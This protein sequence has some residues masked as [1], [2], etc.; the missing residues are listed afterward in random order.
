MNDRQS[1]SF[2]LKK[3]FH[4]EGRRNCDKLVNVNHNKN[5]TNEAKAK[6]KKFFSFEQSLNEIKT[7][8]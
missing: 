3:K 7:K 4:N 6:S 1:F 2:D 8:Q 5:S